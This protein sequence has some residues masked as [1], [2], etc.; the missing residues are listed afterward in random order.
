MDLG[1]KNME[2]ECSWSARVVYCLCIDRGIRLLYLL[3]LSMCLFQLMNRVVGNRSA[4][5]LKMNG[6]FPRLRAVVRIDESWVSPRIPRI[7]I[8]GTTF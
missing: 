1:L 6:T 2:K 7:V 3:F 8:L 4:F 5:E